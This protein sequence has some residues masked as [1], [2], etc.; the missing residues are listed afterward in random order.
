MNLVIEFCLN[1]FSKQI[2]NGYCRLVNCFHKLIRG[3]PCKFIFKKHTHES[4]VMTWTL[5]STFIFSTAFRSSVMSL[6]RSS[7]ACFSTLASSPALFVPLG[8]QGFLEVC[9]E[10]HGDSLPHELTSETDIN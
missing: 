8:F 9:I 7:S 5:S 3:I 6:I 4:R 2:E 10:A 1:V